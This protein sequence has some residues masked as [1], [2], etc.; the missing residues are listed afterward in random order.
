MMV[1]DP[2]LC[3]RKSSSAPR[4]RWLL[5]LAAVLLLAGGMVL[6][7]AS[8]AEAAK[9]GFLGIT[10]NDLSPSKA[11]AY[12]IRTGFA[13][14]VKRVTPN[15]PAQAAGIR[16]KDIIVAA[17]RQM[18]ANRKAFLNFLARNPNRTVQF[19]LIRNGR[20]MNG[21]VRLGAINKRQQQALRNNRPSGSNRKGSVPAN[22]RNN[23][24]A[25]KFP[26]PEK[27]RKAILAKRYYRM[28]FK[29][30]KFFSPNGNTHSGVSAQH[31]RTKLKAHPKVREFYYQNVPPY[32]ACLERWA[33]L[34][35][36]YFNDK[37]VCSIFNY[38]FDH[39][40]GSAKRSMRRAEAE[41]K[42]ENF[43]AKRKAKQRAREAVRS[44]NDAAKGYHKSY[45]VTG[46]EGQGY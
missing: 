3:L 45:G 9:R 16:P 25:Q 44:A 1:I 4:P 8:A 33:K 29:E 22:R 35:K 20:V 13:V 10:F 19:T 18:F 21:M 41:I 17:N 12:R 11:K 6:G 23:R 32:P 37:L 26:N 46:G 43:K 28:S 14:L 34:R 30:A 42:I 38:Y 24:Q 40:V 2:I 5:G 31:I 15:S 36:D 7:Q 27:L 39:L